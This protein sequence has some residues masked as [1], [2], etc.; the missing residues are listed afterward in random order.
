VF[1]IEKENTMLEPSQVAV[2]WTLE[3]LQDQRHRAPNSAKPQRSIRG[4]VGGAVRRFAF[5]TQLGP[6]GGHAPA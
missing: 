3:N 2:I 6:V 4:R 1:S 5:R